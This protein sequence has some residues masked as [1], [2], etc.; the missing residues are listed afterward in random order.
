MQ[1]IPATW[2]RPG[3][4]GVDRWGPWFDLASNQHLPQKLLP[5]EDSKSSNSHKEFQHFPNCAHLTLDT[6]VYFYTTPCHHVSPSF[7]VS[8]SVASENMVTSGLEGFKML[9]K[10]QEKE[11]AHDGPPSKSTSMDHWIPEVS[12]TAEQANQQPQSTM[13]HCQSASPSAL[14]IQSQTTVCID[15]DSSRTVRSGESTTFVA[16]GRPKICVAAEQKLVLTLKTTF[17]IKIFKNL[18]LHIFTF[19]GLTNSNPTSVMVPG[20]KQTIASLS[21]HDI[22]G[23]VVLRSRG[24]NKGSDISRQRSL[25]TKRPSKKISARLNKPLPGKPGYLLGTL[26]LSHAV[27][28]PHRWTCW[29]SIEW[30]KETFL[31][32]CTKTWN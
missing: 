18:N 5:L 21:S 15:Q 32:T 17:R 24:N 28:W 25:F 9:E 20:Q 23:C 27:L 30:R 8:S 26:P 19:A 22:H 16:N 10:V 6:M 12:W 1:P 14:P 11:L 29:V 7:K 2:S 3:T 13:K 4:N 31:C